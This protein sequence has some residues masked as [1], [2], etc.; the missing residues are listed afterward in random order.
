[1][2][3]KIGD[4]VH[5]LGTVLRT[6]TYKAQVA[7]GPEGRD[8]IWVDPKLIVHVWKKA[9][10]VGDLVKDPGTGLTGRIEA[11]HEDFAWLFGVERYPVTVQLGKLVLVESSNV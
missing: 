8:G 1:M 7:F 4:T 5:V 3:C 10:K 9:L 11:I 2:L 6:T